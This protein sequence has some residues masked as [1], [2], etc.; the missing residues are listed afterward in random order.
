[1]KVPD[2]LFHIL[3]EAVPAQVN[4]PLRGKEV[5]R[6]IAVARALEPQVVELRFAPNTLPDPDTLDTASDCLVFIETGEIVT[7]ISRIQEIQG[8]KTV[9]IAVREVIQ[10]VE[11]REYFRGPATRLVLSYREK[12]AEGSGVFYAQGVNIS[13]GGMLMMLTSRLRQKQKLFLEI[14]IP[15]PVEKVIRCEAVVL[16]VNPVKAGGFFTAVRFT[17]MNSGSCDDIMAFCFAEQ[18]RIIRERVITRDLLPPS[19][20]RGEG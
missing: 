13:C 3:R 18:R 19:P 10:H 8:R 2:Y 16:R 20:S 9:Q 15:E 17:R 6:L 4:L 7:L 5:F 12:P 11:K 14:R 1:M